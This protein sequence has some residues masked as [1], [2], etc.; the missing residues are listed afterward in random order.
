MFMTVIKNYNGNNIIKLVES[1]KN[2]SDEVILCVIDKCNKSIE[3]FKL[4]DITNK[5]LILAITKNCHGNNII[6]LFQLIMEGKY[7]ILN[8]YNIT[9]DEDEEMSNK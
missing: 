7:D 8:K 6:K 1:F 5:K 4:I 3:L 9:H 2:L